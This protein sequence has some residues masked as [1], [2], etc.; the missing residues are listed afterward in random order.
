MY[1]RYASKWQ[2]KIFYKGNILNSVHIII[3]STI[4]YSGT[5]AEY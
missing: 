1:I 5:D 4:D 3:S 2:Y